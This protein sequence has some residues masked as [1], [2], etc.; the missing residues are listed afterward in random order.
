MTYS[1][2]KIFKT[3]SKEYS[4]KGSYPSDIKENTGS[5]RQTKAERVCYHQSCLIGNVEM[6]S[7]SEMKTKKYINF[8]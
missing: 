8:E 6:N 7:I 5:P 1:N 2:N 4:N 3:V